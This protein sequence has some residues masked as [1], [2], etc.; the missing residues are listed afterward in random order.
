[1]WKYTSVED[2][3][4][5]SN[6]VKLKVEQKIE[7]GFVLK[8]EGS[9]HAKSYFFPKN[10]DISTNLE[11]SKI[12]QQHNILTVDG[13]NLRRRQVKAQTLKEKYKYKSKD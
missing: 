12:F 5:V 3:I 6:W 9:P 2:T 13:L 10:A 1:M 8:R 4:S 11:F 7:N